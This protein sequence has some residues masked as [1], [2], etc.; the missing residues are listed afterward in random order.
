VH[1]TSAFFLLSQGFNKLILMNNTPPVKISLRALR[2]FVFYV[3]FVGM[4]FVTGYLVGSQKVPFLNNTP[5]SSA[6]LDRS[7]P[8]N[9]DVEFSLFWQVWDTLEGRYF[10]KSKLNAHDMVYGSIKGM[11]AAVGDPYTVF[12]T[13]REN[14]VVQE[15]LKGNF[16]G[17]G[18]Q[19]GFRGTNLAVV[20]P[21]PG[22]PA[23][24]AGI[25]AG[26]LIV[27][28]KDEQKG[29]DRGTV[30]ISL[31]EAVQA[32]RGPAG[33]IVT[34]TLIRDDEADPLFVD[35]ERR[36]IEVPS[37]ALEYVGEDQ[38]I[39][40]IQVLKF[41][42]ET[43]D[44]W[45]NA[46]LD[47]IKKRDLKGIIVDVRNNTGGYLQA[48]VDLASEFI[49][50]GETVVI[51]DHGNGEKQSFA[52]ERMGRLMKEP[53]VV[54]VNQGSASAS[55]ILAG[56]LRDQIDAPLVG[57]TTFGKGTIQEPQQVEGGAGLHIT[58]ARWLTP[59]EFWVNEVGL[60]PDVI[61]ENDPETAD[62][63]EQLQAAIDKINSIN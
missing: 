3:L 38:N 44:E 27:G 18:I 42:A 6:N 16:E 29:I 36:A 31:P 46:V 55:E 1:D 13:P 30:G 45:N 10:D 26:D 59:S 54:L 34:L 51:E 40:H 41:G 61:I 12:L 8:E 2:R 60:E 56:A 49:E 47:V 52:V 39:A 4:I 43:T 17:V 11:V 62:Q 20:S 19:I 33:S 35:V 53:V 15:D 9:E 14:T 57:Q 25:Q 23:D 50:V 24:E 58:I 7:V 21:M 37:V 5:L 22:T 32:I 28:I 63:D 48:A